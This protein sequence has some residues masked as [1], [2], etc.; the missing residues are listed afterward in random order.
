MR[1]I[2]VRNISKRYGQVRA[3][4]GVTLTFEEGKI[5]G[6]LGRNGAGKST[7]LGMISNRVFADDGEVL[8]A[9]E[10]AFEN[11]RAQA[12]VYVMSEKDYYPGSMRVKDVFRWTNAFYQGALRM[13]LALKLCDLFALDPQKK[14]KQLSTGYGS[15]YKIITALS[16]TVPFLLL[17]E[18]V[19]GLD[20]YHRDL[21]Y[22]VMLENYAE[23]P[24]TIVISTH[25]IEEVSSLLEEVI[26]IKSGKIVEQAPIERL[27]ASGYTVTGPAA[28][29]DAY[30]RDKNKI[31]EDT[32]G[33]VKAAY[34]LGTPDRD[35][36]PAQLEISRID[37]QKLFIQLTNQ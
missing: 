22:K 14:V 13:E 2:E 5:Y 27:L 20:A 24:R 32:L 17:D 28:I 25:L 12:N 21:L 16:L 34:A 29:V 10:S 26:I 18:P 31:G 33:G 11:D 9:G 23:L 30:M 15:I 37:L 19:L 35:N 7:L 8:I 4:D 6:L 1:K 3:V 36:V